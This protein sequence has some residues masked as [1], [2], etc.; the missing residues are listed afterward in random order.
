[1]SDLPHKDV[2]LPFIQRVFDVMGRADW[3]TFQVLT[4]RADRLERVAAELP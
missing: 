2:P 3:H 1:M 4:K